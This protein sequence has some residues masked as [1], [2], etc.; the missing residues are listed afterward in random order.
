MKPLSKYIAE[1]I[2]D[3]DFDNQVDIALFYSQECFTNPFYASYFEPRRTISPQGIKV[4]GNKIA[5]DSSFGATK[6]PVDKV[7]WTILKNTGIDTAVLNSDNRMVINTKAPDIAIKPEN[8]FKTIVIDSPVDFRAALKDI[9]LVLN[10]DMQRLPV[11][12]KCNIETKS[13]NEIWIYHLSN[14]QKCKIDSMFKRLRID[15]VTFNPHDPLSD[16]DI[17]QPI[18]PKVNGRTR[19][20]KTPWDFAR[21]IDSVSTMVIKKQI[22]PEDYASVIEGDVICVRDDWEKFADFNTSGINVITF[23]IFGIE[24]TGLRGNHSFE[25]V[26]WFVPRSARDNYMPWTLTNTGKWTWIASTSDKW[27]QPR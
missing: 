16:A 19:K 27:K 4:N 9:T 18:S 11:M 26:S 21:F 22:A 24:I 17:L 25:K 10:T 12:T 6:L 1:G 20:I 15:L 3:D 8:F 23:K 14:I 13:E 2:F 5:I 7:D